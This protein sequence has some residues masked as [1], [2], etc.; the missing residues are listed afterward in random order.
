MIGTIV[1]IPQGEYLGCMD[2]TA[3]NFDPVANV[4]DESCLYNDICCSDLTPECLAC[5]ACQTPEDWCLNNPGYNGC[6][7]Y[8]VVGCMDDGLQDWSPFPGYEAD[9]YEPGANTPGECAYWGCG[10]RQHI[11]VSWNIYG[12]KW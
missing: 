2:E 8:D 12:F 9:N 5:Q 6:D 1:V 10:N 7:A 4:D 3:C 11:N